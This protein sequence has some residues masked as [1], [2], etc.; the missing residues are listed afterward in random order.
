MLTCARACSRVADPMVRTPAHAPPAPVAGAASGPPTRQAGILVALLAA[1]AL[2]GLLFI[3]ASSQTSD[4]A[5]HIAAGY[6]YLTRVDFRLN[7]E[8][9][10]LLKEIAALPLLALDLSFPD[11]A[12]WERAEEWN[13]GRLFVHENRVANDTILLLTRLPMLALGI[14]LALSMY[15]WG[16]ELFGPRAALLPIA[17]FVL[18]PT[19]V[20][21]SSLVTTDVGFTFFLFLSIWSLWSWSRRPSPRGL[22]LAGLAIGGAFASKFTAVWL[23]PILAGLAIGLLL[24]GQA[25]PARPWSGASREAAGRRFS[26][27]RIG[28]VLAAGAIIALVALAVLAATYAFSGLPHFVEGLRRGLH[29]SAIG[30]TAYL[31]GELS[32][33]GWWYYFPYAFL[34]KTPIGTLILIALSVGALALGRRMPLRDEMFLWIPVILILGMTSLWKVNIGLRHLLPIYPFLYLSAGRLLTAPRSEPRARSMPGWAAAALR[35]T[36]VVCLAH[37]VFEAARFTPHQLA[38]FNPLVGGPEN[39]HRHLLDSNLDWGQGAKSLRRFMETEGVPAIYCAFSG[40]SDPWYVGVR[41]EYVPGSGN[42]E[43]PKRRFFTVPDGLPRVLLAVSPMVRYSTHFTEHDL[44][45]W[46]DAYEPVAM[47]GYA[48][49]VYDITGDVAALERIAAL[50][51]SF[52]LYDLAQFEARRI[53]RLDPRN[54]IARAILERLPGDAGPALPGSQRGGPPRSSSRTRRASAPIDPPVGSSAEAR[55]RSV[56]ASPDSPRR[57]R[58]SPSPASGTGD[59]GARRIASR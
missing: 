38:Y 19:V 30:H 34:I 7:P 31:R 21:H 18:D 47:P 15:L 32:E 26:P 25:L 29:H 56:R 57:Y 50:D 2:Q 45:D 27:G 51:F 42:L 53:L 17:L 28:S 20:A 41:Y 35:V 10:P 54:A 48:Y 43:N 44:Y 1:F 40:N 12:L 58:R 4:E 9:P 23:L 14:A 3:T 22:I 52:R 6:S 36:V 5:A 11:G 59:D 8:H 24:I 49:L 55:S 33:T 13:T 39:G 16:R 46:L 37:N